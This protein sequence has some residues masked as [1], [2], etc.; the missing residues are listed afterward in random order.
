MPDVFPYKL[1]TSY[2]HMMPEDVLVWER[3]IQAKPTAFEKVEYDVKV[4]R[5]PDFVKNEPDEAQRAQ[6]PLYQRKIDVVGYSLAIRWI[7]ELKPI[8]TTATVGQVL[9]Y[10]HLYARDF[11][12]EGETR[13]MIICGQMDEDTQ[14]FARS[15]EVAVVVV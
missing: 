1:L 11:S 7:V 8:A 2:P 9:G 12:P 14:E 6:A 13:A 15:Q 3:F 5:V 4:G 10:A